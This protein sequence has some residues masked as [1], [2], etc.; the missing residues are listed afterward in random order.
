LESL[1]KNKK[2]YFDDLFPPG[3]ASLYYNPRDC[4]FG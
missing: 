3:A 4:K 2:K 1:K